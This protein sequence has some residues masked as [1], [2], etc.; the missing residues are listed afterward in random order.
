M[1]ACQAPP[2]HVVCLKS[3]TKYPADYANRLHRMVG[4]HLDVA[5]EFLC[6]TDD[7]RG[8]DEGI[9]AAPLAQPDLGGTWNK[10]RFFDPG[11]FPPGCP[12]LY[13]DLDVVITG[14]LAP[15]LEVPAGTSF[16]GQP[17]W[18]RPWFPQFNGSVIFFRAGVHDGILA[19]FLAETSAG[20]LVRRNE[21]DATTR[22]HD[23]A[24][25]WRGWRRF[26]S[27]QE[28]ISWH[29]RRRAG[30]PAAKFP[31]GRIVSYKTHARRGVPPGAAI[32]VFHGSP[33]PHE[34]DH[35][36]VRENWG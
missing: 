34:V 19:D 9:R 31:R 20:K 2:L 10:L 24:V 33:K 21:W 32:V 6:L 26:G 18:N 5:H 11:L 1:E 23:K 16:V 29:L 36:Y 25:Y 3:G 15:L 4:R 22:G 30:R 17:D 35:A 12:V 28:W 14:P 13:L 27:D 7:A 8:L